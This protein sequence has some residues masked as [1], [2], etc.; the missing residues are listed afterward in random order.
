MRY[1]Y[2]GFFFVLRGEAWAIVKMNDMWARGT[3]LVVLASRLLFGSVVIRTTI[4][5]G[6]PEYLWHTA[7]PSSYSVRVRV[8][9]LGAKTG[10]FP[11]FSDQCFVLVMMVSRLLP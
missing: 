8:V 1:L 11:I 4:Q 3:L 10:G 7:F 2:A 5:K 6:V 9:G